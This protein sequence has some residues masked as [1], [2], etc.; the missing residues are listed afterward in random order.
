VQGTEHGAPPLPVHHPAFP[1]QVDMHP[2]DTT[3]PCST[4]LEEAG[5]KGLP[6]VGDSWRLSLCLGKVFSQMTASN[7]G[8]KANEHTV[9][10]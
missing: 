5:G 3:G 1:A 7:V 2:G 6:I 8:R 4:D 10:R 9:L